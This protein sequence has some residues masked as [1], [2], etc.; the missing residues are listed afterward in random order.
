MALIFTPLICAVIMTLLV[1]KPQAARIVTLVMLAVVIIISVFLAVSLWNYDGGYFT[2]QMGYLPGPFGNEIR[3]GMLEAILAVVFSSVMFLIILG[4]K[5]DVEKDINENRRTLYLVMLSLITAALMALTFTNDIFTA[6]VFIEV[7]TIS[8]CTIVAV[9][10]NKATLKATVKYLFLSMVGSGLFLFAVSILYSI[11]GHLQMSY[12]NATIS[13]LIATGQYEFPLIVVL[14][15]FIVGLAIKGALF[16]FHTWL[17]EAHGSATS[18][19]SAVLSSL[20]LKGYAVILLKILFRMYGIE[21]IYQMN[22]LPVLF[23]L[24]V[25]GMLAGSVMAIFQKNIKRLV[26]Y[27]S[28]A[29]IGYIYMGF[30]LAHQ[31]GFVA[32]GYHII[33][34]SATKAMLFVAAGALIATAGTNNLDDMR[35]AA[36][37]NKLAGIAFV[38]GSLSM[39]GVPLFAGFVSKFYL[40][41]AAVQA[42]SN[43]VLVF[44]VLA[45]SAF[46]NSLYYFNALVKLYSKEK[47]GAEFSPKKLGVSAKVA[48]VCFILANIALGVFFG[49]LLRALEAGFGVLG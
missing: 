25:I 36:R 24:G 48:L 26:A 42:Q 35:G 11:T 2:Y 33:A 21:A 30:G 43:V 14:L 19:S 28:V 23:T 12:I 16:P 3:A 45:V 32:A 39:V 20:V 22:I 13:E 46:L 49:P 37:K 47:D 44:A 18:P 41:G 7:C 38:A 40:A 34:H 29:Q 10:E 6:F 15:L 8:A 31:A 1:K 9:K 17:P 4:T 27:S 5:K